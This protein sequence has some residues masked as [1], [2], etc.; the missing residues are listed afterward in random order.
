MRCSENGGLYVKAARAVFSFVL[1][2]IRELRH[3]S[4]AEFGSASDKDQSW[5]SIAERQHVLAFCD[6][7]GGAVREARTGRRSGLCPRRANGSDPYCR[8]ARF[9]DDLRYRNSAV[10]GERFGSDSSGKFHRIMEIMGHP[11]FPAQPILRVNRLRLHALDLSPTW[12]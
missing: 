12:R 8:T 10:V 3:E 11:A 7:R 2:A 5:I 6:Q 1:R 9:H 4:P